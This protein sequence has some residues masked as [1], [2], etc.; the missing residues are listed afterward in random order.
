MLVAG[1]G[2]YIHKTLRE[3]C[4]ALK[5]LEKGESTKDVG[6]KYNVPK[7]TLSAWVKNKEELFDALEKRTNVKRQKLKSDNHE[8]MDQAICNW[9]LNMRNQNVPLSASMISA[10]RLS[11]FRWLAAND[12]GRKEI[13]YH[14]RL[15]PGSRNLSHQ[16]WLMCDQKRPFQL[17]CQTMT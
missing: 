17:F 15:F 6:A 16:R 5:T 4:Q 11:G 3:K 2:R 1:I 14:S 13:M 8:L 9:F 12:A 10:S 7:N